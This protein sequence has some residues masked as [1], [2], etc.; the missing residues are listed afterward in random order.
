M[1]DGSGGIVVH[2]ACAS[3]IWQA[4]VR[5]G[6]DEAMWLRYP[7]LKDEVVEIAILGRSR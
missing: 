5:A 6:I 3:S 7:R 4:R 1:R 2:E